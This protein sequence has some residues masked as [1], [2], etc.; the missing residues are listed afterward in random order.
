MWIAIVFFLIGFIVGSILTAVLAIGSQE[1][2]LKMR[3]DAARFEGYCAAYQD[4]RALINDENLPPL[5]D[6]FKSIN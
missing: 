5:E 1:D 6:R 3:E 2:E 4:L